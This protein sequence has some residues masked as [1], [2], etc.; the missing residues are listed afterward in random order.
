MGK[1][2]E[3]CSPEE[4]MA[5]IEAYFATV[6]L[7]TDALWKF[8]ALSAQA[9]TV[10]LRS[11][12][13]ARALTAE[14]DLELLKNKRRAFLHQGASINPPSQDVVNKAIDRAQALADKLA[15]EAEAA[16]IVALV[17]DGLAAFNQIQSA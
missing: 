7:L 1:T 8:E 14:R 10:A 16:A 9:S 11:H 5:Y 12:Y 17:R 6:D 3:N 4:A 2:R 13:R 15:E